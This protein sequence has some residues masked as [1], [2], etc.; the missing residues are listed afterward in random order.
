MLK[1]KA[2]MCFMKWWLNDR[3]VFSKYEIGK[4]NLISVFKF[5][6]QLFYGHT[7]VEF[8]FPLCKGRTWWVS[9]KWRGV[10]GMSVIRAIVIFESKHGP[11]ITRNNYFTL[12]FVSFHSFSVLVVCLSIC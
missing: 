7:N 12:H 8:P 10:L 4:M 11:D 1:K 9:D 5:N 6:L 3:L 2:S